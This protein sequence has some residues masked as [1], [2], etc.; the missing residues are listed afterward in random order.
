M[1][2]YSH[3]IYYCTE[4]RTFSLFSR[5]HQPVLTLSLS[6][7]FFFHVPSSHSSTA[8]RAGRI[9][10]STARIKVSRQS[11]LLFDQRP[12]SEAAFRGGPPAETLISAPRLLGPSAVG[13]RV[14]LLKLVLVEDLEVKR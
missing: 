12:R 5:C 3:F 13:A 4:I 14:R 1:K 9:P 6:P 7:F 11:S 2:K 10:L 8:Q